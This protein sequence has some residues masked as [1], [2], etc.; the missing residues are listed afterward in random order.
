MWKMRPIKLV[1]SAFGPY[2]DRTPEIDFERFEDRGL[3]LIAG[4]TGAGKT[5]IFDAICFALYGEASGSHRDTK[6]LRSEYAREGTECFVE[7]TFSHQGRQ[8][9]IRREPSYERRKQRGEGFVTVSEKAVLYCEDK[10]PT[11][12]KK[13]VDSAVEELLHIDSHQFK[14]IAMI[15]QGEFWDLLNAKTEERTEILR[16]IFMTGGYREIE[17]GLKRRMD[18]AVGR[19]KN[20]EAAI[21]QYFRDVMPCEGEEGNALREL[22]ERMKKDDYAL[23]SLEELQNAIRSA[24]EA[25]HAAEAATGEKLKAVEE[26]LAEKRRLLATAETNNALIDRRE[27]LAAER[28]R[29]LQ[30]GAE[31]DGLAKRLERQRAA[32]RV[33]KLPYELWQKKRSDVE[34]T[35]TSLEDGRKRLEE[36]RTNAEIAGK[37]LDEAVSREPEAEKLRQQAERINEDAGRY[38]QRDTLT[39]ELS[40]LKK[41]AAALAEQAGKLREEENALKERCMLL[42][43]KCSALKDRPERLRTAEQLG[44]EL[45]SLERSM[46]EL[47]GQRRSAYEERRERLSNAQELFL[48]AQ[49][50]YREAAE[51]RMH[52]EELL[53]GCRAGILAKGLQEGKKCPVCGALHH[54]EPAELPDADITEDKIRELKG[55]EEAAQREKEAANSDAVRERTALEGFAEQFLTDMCACLEHPLCAESKTEAVTEE[56]CPKPFHEDGEESCTPRMIGELA[57]QVCTMRLKLQDRLKENKTA[58]DA[59]EKECGELEAAEAELES[60]QG[61]KLEALR[62]RLED[63]ARRREENGRLLAEKTALS[64]TLEELAYPDW[65][66]AA[67]ARDT[68]KEAAAALTAT[69]QTARRRKEAADK[70]EHDSD[71]AVRLLTETL[72]GQ[73]CEEQALMAEFETARKGQNFTDTAEVLQF[74]TEEAEIAAAEKLLQDY[75]RSVETNAA[76]LR[77]AEEDAAGKSRIDLELLR[78]EVEEQESAAGEVNAGLTEVRYRIRNNEDKCGRISG[79]WP[80]FESAGRLGAVCTRLYRLVRGNTGNGKITLEQYVQ[81]AGFD[82]I[83]MAANRRLLP[84]SDG[85]YELFRQE[86]SI[87]RKSNT[88]LDLEVLDHFTGR[89]RPVGNLSG[90]E[91]FKASL[92]LALGLSDTVSSHLGGVQMDALFIDEGFGTLDRKSIENA[93]DILIHLAGSNKLVGVISHR[94]ELIESIPQ[95][96]KV[97]KTREGSR[98]TIEDGR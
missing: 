29:L 77:Q 84:M 8:Y 13:E 61:E 46:E 57:E 94:E 50:K 75:E 72:V 48:K 87:G 81:A 52:A 42:K 66:A 93:M 97:E 76:Q 79:L 98:I 24:T 20:V 4:D 9:R 92:S 5:T 34:A 28:G 32:T 43:E 7:F 19:K 60:A 59:L 74:V 39:G 1:M 17:F 82:N 3:F 68:A 25:D 89:R 47:T 14:Q 51:K 67:K 10:A 96:I 36:A 90:G 11:E 83:I 21:L 56:S 65:T 44:E 69:I 16:T 12:G 62:A 31:M 58:Q 73:Q 63:C 64:G 41:D 26:A 15:A 37:A 22:Q 86:D 40:L 49:D 80:E 27:A 85:Q 18:E 2:A 54:P 33:C 55:Q 45:I 6:N 23:W 95:Q 53:D 91:S 35:K 30:Q 88:F 71:A 38:E 70:E 78:A